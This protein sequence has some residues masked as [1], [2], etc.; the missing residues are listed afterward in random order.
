MRALES[1]SYLVVVVSKDIK[2]E[3]G[4]RNALR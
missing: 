2:L 1:V 4:G 3:M